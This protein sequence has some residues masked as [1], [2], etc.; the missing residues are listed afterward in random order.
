MA[1][2]QPTCQTSGWIKVEK[3]SRLTI[4]PTLRIPYSWNGLNFLGSAGIQE[5]AYAADPASPSPSDVIHHEAFV[6]EGDVNAQFLKESST[7]LLGLGNVQSI[8][9]PRLQYSYDQNTTSFGKVPS[10]DPR[11]GSSTRTRSTYSLNHYSERG[12]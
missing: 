6:A 5:K 3:D 10:I 4:A 8:I 1:T 11:T 7:T 9:T 2:W 12:K